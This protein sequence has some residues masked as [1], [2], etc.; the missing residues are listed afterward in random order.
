MTTIP[1]E[2]KI[3]INTSIPG[4]QKIEYKPS[5]TITNIS[6]DDSSIRF[7]PLIKLDKKKP[8]SLVIL[9]PLHKTKKL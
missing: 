9:F 8:S 2:L 5:M 4:Y 6:S 7:N 3:T 1:N